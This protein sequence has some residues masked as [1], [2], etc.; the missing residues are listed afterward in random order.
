MSMLRS[1]FPDFTLEDSLPALEKV[2]D[3]LLKEFPKQHERIFN[4]GSMD[5]GI[6]QHTQVT[7]I[8]AVG[9]VGEG[10]EY[11]MDE[12]YPGYDKTFSAIKYGVIMPITEELLDDSMTDVFNRRP[13]QLAR[14]M[15]EAE[16]ISAAS[17]FNNGF[18]DVGPDGVSLFNVSHPLAY[19]GA[20][21]S[22]NTLS[23]PA[24]LSLSALEDLVTVM[25]QTK[26]HAGKKI[27][28]RPQVLCVPPELEFLAHE[29]L[30][31]QMKPQASTASNLTE[32]NAVNAI[33]G[34]YGLRVE[35][36]DYLTDSDAFF[37]IGDKA[38]HNLWWYW[39]KRPQVSSDMEFKSDIALLKIKARWAVGYSDWK[40]VAGSPGV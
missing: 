14:A 23:S 8:P 27:V 2:T 9:S 32:E 26:D 18:G 15:N 21:V 10:S 30:E 24:D 35:V 4:V 37:L 13:Q 16:R 1:K 25:R 22:S 20:G 40:G 17:I 33:R 39:R 38:D 12:M 34:R 6:L 28:I 3:D 36:L 31:S 11:P 5:K 19:P 29:L 7:G